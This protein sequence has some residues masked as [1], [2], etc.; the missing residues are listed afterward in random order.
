MANWDRS[1]RELVISAAAFCDSIS[2]LAGAASRI[3]GFAVSD[4][5]VRCAWQRWRKEDPTLPLLRDV[6]EQ[7]NKTAS[8]PVEYEYS[9]EVYDEWDEPTVPGIP[10][11]EVPAKNTRVEDDRRVAAEW[12]AVDGDGLGSIEFVVPKEATAKKVPKPDELIVPWDWSSDP[13]A[14]MLVE[15]DLHFPLHDKRAES[16]KLNFAA[17]YVPDMWAHLGDGYDLTTLSRFDHDP[18]YLH[19]LQDEFT[20]CDEH[21]SVACQIA[22][23]VKFLLGN[24]EWRLEKTVFANHALFG[25]KALSDWH[26]LAGIPEKV[27]IHAYGS[28]VQVGHAWMEHGDQ[29]RGAS[30]PTY[31]AWQHR[32]GRLGLFGH[33][34]RP[35]FYAKS[36]RLEDGS[37]GRREFYGLGHGQDPATCSKWAGTVTGWTSGFA[38]VEHFTTAGKWDFRVTPILT[39][40]GV[41]HFNGKTYRA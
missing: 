40:G 37:I 7:S 23:R 36:G 11:V 25:L 20:S 31:W 10:V 24:H 33:N 22:K 30:N 5:A 4:G 1:T 38:V 8:I 13:P 17:D 27:E 2:D 39:E 9:A 41:V 12:S 28:Q 6:L 29:V 18:A 3:T 34:H 19:T 14:K 21:W 35:S 32:G 26:T 15:T 16:A